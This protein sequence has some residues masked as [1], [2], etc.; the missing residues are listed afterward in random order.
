M[1]RTALIRSVAAVIVMSS[2][3]G[4][5][6]RPELDVSSP[7]SSSIS[8][9]SLASS[10]SSTS[11]TSQHNEA[12]VAFQQALVLHHGQSTTAYDVVLAKDGVDQRVRD[13]V[14]RVRDVEAA[15]TDQMR[16]SLQGWGEDVPAPLEDSHR[17][18]VGTGKD[19]PGGL[20]DEDLH[21]LTDVDGATASRAFLQLMIVHQADAIEIARA[22]ISGGSDPEA[23]VLARTVV[24]MHQSE[25]AEMRALLQVL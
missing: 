4:V 14:G 18:A 10:T 17:G 21:T 2:G 8:S 20:S 25:I 19:G 15:Q 13:L 22:E 7:P 3:C 23:I 1:A 9:R 11:S 6:D 5:V 16:A 24:E 12:D